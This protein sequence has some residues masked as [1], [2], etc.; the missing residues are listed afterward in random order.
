MSDSSNAR[1][2]VTAYGYRRITCKD[3]KQR[4]EHVMVWESHFGPVP[5]GME[6]HHVNGD[7]LDNRIENLKALTRLQHKRL[8][9]GCIRV[10]DGWLRQCR[11][12]KWFRPI[13]TDYYV[14]PGRSGVMGKCK[15]C[16]VDLAV[17]AKRR[18]KAK[19]QRKEAS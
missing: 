17:E 9:S 19:R 8:H 6:I 2:T 7:K 11:R 12:C 1:G 10:G 13:D 4:F 3:R 18:R 15:R 16:L 14:Y 5:K